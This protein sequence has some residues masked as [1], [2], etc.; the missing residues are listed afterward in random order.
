M[1]RVL[2][3]DGDPRKRVTELQALL[4]RTLN[5]KLL[6]LYLFG[7]LA[8]DRFN[9]ARSDLDLL[10]V[11]E[12]DLD[13]AE[14]GSL[15]TLH[16]DFVRSHPEWENRVEVGYIS[17]KGLA[18]LATSPE[19]KIAA[20]SPGEPLH[21]K[22][23]E[24]DWLINWYD[25]CTHAQALLGPAPIALGPAI[26]EA[27]YRDAVVAQLDGCGEEVRKPWVPQSKPYQGYL[28][29]TMCRGLYGL[30]EGR[31][32]TKEQS[33]SWAAERFPQWAAFIRDALARHRSE[34]CEG[35][36]NAAPYPE[37]VRFVDFALQN[38]RDMGHHRRA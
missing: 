13:D 11:L 2:P 28:V 10:A 9:L 16:A 12:D 35:S 27:E 29:V 26:G 24:V 23:L 31:Q 18:S 34:F 8:A 25:V 20:I 22:P 33:A 32:T 1:T 15:E 7:S 3:A 21:F 4:E 14:L 37:T 17:R 38:A 5:G 19:G 6:G 36:D 30:S